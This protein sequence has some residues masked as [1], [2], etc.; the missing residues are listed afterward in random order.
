MEDAGRWTK[1]RAPLWGLAWAAAVGVAGAHFI[2]QGLLAAGLLALG[3]GGCWFF[4]RKPWLLWVTAVLV[5]YVYGDVRLN[6][7]ARDG[8]VRFAADLP[9]TMTFRGLIAGEVELKTGVGGERKEF[10][11]ELEELWRDG[12]WEPI[13]GA[14]LASVD[15][16]EGMA[17][18]ACGDRLEATGFVRQPTGP[19]N[20]GEFDQARYLAWRRLDYLWRMESSSLRVMETGVGAWRERLGLA[21]RDFMNERVHLGLKDDP[22]ISALMAGMLFGY[23]EGISV[24]VNEAF[25]KTGTLHLFAVSGQNVA[26]IIGVLILFLQVVGILRWRWGWVLVPIIF[27][28]CLGTGLQPSAVRASVM[29]SFVLIGWAL[30][31]PIHPLNI[32]GA[33][34]LTIWLWDPREL[35]DLGFQLSFLVVVALV[36]VAGPLARWWG[37]SGAPDPW[38]PA[39]LVP[40]WRWRVFRGWQVVVAMGAVSLAAW[41]ASTPLIAWHFHLISTI[42]VVA[43]LIVVPLASL[44]VVISGL[45]VVF[46]TA[47]AGLAVIFN[48]VNWL[49]LKVIVFLVQGLA[50]IPG[51]A[52]YWNPAQSVPKDEISV[53]VLDGRRAFPS[54]VREPGR[55]WLIDTGS[56]SVW[57][58]SVDPARRFLAVNRW[59]GVILTQGSRSFSGGAVAL[60]EAMPVG[61]WAESGWRSRSRDWHAWLDVMEKEGRSKQFWSRG[62]RILLSDQ[63]RAEV[64]WPPRDGKLSRLEDQGL[65]IRLVTPHGTILWAGEISE[66]VETI[67]LEGDLEVQADILIQGEHSQAGN[68]SVAWLERVG[69]KHLIRPRPGFQLDR[70]LSP[71][72]WAWAER[73]GSRVWLMEQT[74]AV[75]VE[76][77]EGRWD[78]RSFLQKSVD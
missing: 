13:R 31:R 54:I 67:L 62:D 43:N 32:L 2:P 37:K 33:A 16:S 45:S 47:W 77:R 4:W 69:A 48:Q 14:V 51:S 12:R 56:E 35:F 9:R 3:C 46:G 8:L 15:V 44:V 73:H 11:F 78:V 60:A 63:L 42:T 55:A 34:A 41:A 52:F 36:L 19:R 68:W 58:H 40:K 53:W 25:R 71:A 49:L 7:P 17:E 30:L 64:L 22:E 66:A 6:L 59:E 23:R 1:R 28:F 76:G 21:V 29:A 72:V 39:R 20:P 74:G 10:P 50:S 38:I 61:F 5:F 26:V 24:E 18:F 57:R 70:G 65:V 75:H 27:L